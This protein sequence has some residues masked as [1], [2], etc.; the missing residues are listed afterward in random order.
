MQSGH[1][2]RDFSYFENICFYNLRSKSLSEIKEI[3]DVNEGLENLIQ[4]AALSCNT[5]DQ[6][7]NIVKS[8]RYTESRIKRILLYSLLNITKKDMDI[9]KKTIPYA[10]VLGLNDKGKHLISKIN[11]AN[12]NMKVITSVKKF[13]DTNNNKNL[14]ILLNKDIY[15]TNIYTL[16]YENDSWGNLD[17]TQKISE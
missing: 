1:F 16:G 11:K 9:S 10:R 6:F 15:A 4:K 8:K 12:S 17:F 14:Q 2:V 13:I 5:E 7:I 3:A